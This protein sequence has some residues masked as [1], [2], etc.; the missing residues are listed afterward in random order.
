MS[1]EDIA[2]HYRV[3]ASKMLDLVIHL[4]DQVEE[5][6]RA[7]KKARV[8]SVRGKAPV[9]LCGMGGS[10]IG[11]QLLRDLIQH[12]AAVPLYLESTYALPAFADKTTPVI[13]IS[14]SGN[15]KE[16]LSCFQNALMRGCPA[17]VITSGGLLAEEADAAGVRVIRVPAG[18]P[19]R[20]ALGHLFVPLISLVSRWGIYPVTDEEVDSAVRKSRKLVE[21]YSLEADPVDSRALQLAKRLYGKTP[22]IYSGD[23]LLSAAAYRWKCQFNENS[24][25]MAFANRF[26][27]LGHNEIMGWECPERLRS[28]YFLIVLRDGEDHPRVQRGMEAAYKMLEPLVSGAALIDSEGDEGRAGRLGR[29]LSI[30]LLGDFTSVYLAVE[31]GRDPTPIEKIER[32]KEELRMEDA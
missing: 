32:I 12:D 11:A 8:Q 2:R 15:T 20:A 10:S 19:P 18:M 21:K 13:C 25:S 3:D 7:L 1:N 6:W 5:S 17:I 14:Y 24:K 4:P 29:L 9:V 23:G 16:V 26:P 22:I 27:E 30:I 28:D 31:Y